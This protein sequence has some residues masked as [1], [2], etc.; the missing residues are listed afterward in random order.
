MKP[1]DYND[2][3]WEVRSSIGLDCTL[4]YEVLSILKYCCSFSLMQRTWAYEK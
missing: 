2:E 3:E 4:D 1:D